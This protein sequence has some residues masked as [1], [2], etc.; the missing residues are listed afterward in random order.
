MKTTFIVKKIKE[1]GELSHELTFLYF[2]G[3]H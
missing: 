1:E 3:M 2:F